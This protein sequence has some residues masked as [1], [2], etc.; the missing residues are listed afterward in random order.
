MAWRPVKPSPAD[1][2]AGAVLLAK[3]GRVR[4]AVREIERA[5]LVV[6]QRASRRQQPRRGSA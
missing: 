2:A 4:E 1:I 6:E 5:A 3:Q